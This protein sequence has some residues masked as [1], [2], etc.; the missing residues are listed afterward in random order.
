MR[1]RHRAPNEVETCKGRLGRKVSGWAIPRWP[2]S[3]KVYK[4]V[5]GGVNGKVE[6]KVELRSSCKIMIGNCELTAVGEWF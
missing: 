1:S 3:E 5:S 2:I 6:E 4:K